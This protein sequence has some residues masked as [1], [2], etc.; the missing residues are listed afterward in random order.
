MPDRFDLSLLSVD[1]MYAADAGAIA[2]GVNGES[3]MENAGSGLAR[4]ITER[5]QPCR[6]VILCGPGN[7]GGDGFVAARHLR[8]AGYSV[9]VALLGTRELLKGDAATMAAR[10]TGDVVAL[11]PGVVASTELIIDGIFGA[12]L[13]RPIDGVAA[14]TIEAI[15]QSGASVVAIDMPSGVHGDSGGVLGTAPTASLTVTFFLRK[16]GHLLMPGRELMGEVVT[17][18]IGIPLDVLDE[19][20]PATFENGPALWNEAFPWPQVADHKYSR[21]HAIV[22]SGA[23]NRTGAA[24]LAAR[25]ALRSGA[26][27]VTVACP[28][29]A[30][31]VNAAQLTSVMCTSFDG[32]EGLASVLDDQRRNAVLLGPGNGVDADTR[33]E[34]LAALSMNKKVVLDADALTVF[35]DKPAALFDAIQGACVLTPHEGEFRKLFPDISG[36]NKL[37]RAREAAQRSGATVLFKGPDTV[38]AA[39]DRRASINTVAAPELAT[40]GSGDVLSGIIT[41]LIAQG[42]PTFE[43]ASAG[44]WL[45]GVAAASFGPGLI[46]E[47]IIEYIPDALTIFRDQS[48]DTGAT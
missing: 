27:L 22:V 26:G 36:D 30:L 1:E 8:D 20:A 15:Q 48:E 18:D 11:E 19:I 21:G 7:N 38:I 12:G 14:A 44:A 46:A 16:S 43:A 4:V 6:V 37:Q 23:V 25:A 28:P 32:V 3:L 42:M 9:T 29:D 24:R 2:A 13:A 47:D 39:A 10:W 40:A 34:V 41:G 33:S 17:V 5:W 31:L 45:H 35:E